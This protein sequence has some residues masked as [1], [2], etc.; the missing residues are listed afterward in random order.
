MS[1]NQ[2]NSNSIFVIHNTDFLSSP[3]HI[4]IYNTSRHCLKLTYSNS[5]T[6]DLLIND[7]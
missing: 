1:Q 2:V 3:I 7:Y 5:L 4:S 6:A